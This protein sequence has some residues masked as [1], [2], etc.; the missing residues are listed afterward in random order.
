MQ[1]LFNEEDIQAAKDVVKTS[2]NNEI[3]KTLY[4]ENPRAYLKYIH[5]GNAYYR[6]EI[7]SLAVEQWFKV[8]IADMGE[9]RFFGQENAKHLIRWMYN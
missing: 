9:G 4:K 7:N 3:K 8:P 6:A 5:L 2:E 1:P